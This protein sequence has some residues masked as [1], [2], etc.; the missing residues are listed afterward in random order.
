MTR[1]RRSVVLGPV[2]SCAP[3]LVWIW[4][5]V[6]PR[7]NRA[8]VLP[9]EH[10]LIVTLVS[11]LAAGVALFVVRIALAL[12]QYQVLLIAL[13]FM[14]MAA[15]FTVHALATPGVHAGMAAPPPSDPYDYAVSTIS[16]P[17]PIDY[18]ST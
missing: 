18:S 15:F 7:V 16:I 6:D 2:L 14:S 13:G 1:A 5:L 12:E 8:V 17:T 11:L 9:S 3:A 4:L 10:F